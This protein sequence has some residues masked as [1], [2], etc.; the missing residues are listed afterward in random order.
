VPDSY[1]PARHI[2]RDLRF[3]MDRSEES[4]L[5][6]RM[7][8][9]P[10]LLDEH[11]VL[12]AGALGIATDVFGG[13]LSIEAALPDWAVT[14]E[15]Q[16]H[17]LGQVTKG[18]VEVRGDVLRSGRTSV[19]LEVEVLDGEE[20]SAAVGSM[21]F[22]KIKRRHDNPVLPVDRPASTTLALEDS[23]FRSP[24]LDAIGV[25]DAPD[26]PAAIE[27]DLAPYVLN[28][29]DALQGG[30]VTTLVEVVAARVASHALGKPVVTTDFS[31][32]FLSLGTAGPI[33]ASA[34]LLRAEGDHALLRVEL[35]DRGQENRLLSMAT[36]R[37]GVLGRPG[38]S[39]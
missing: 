28:S 3:D 17:V 6:V 18:P 19:V 9:V 37:A 39:R 30:L 4:G 14:S 26:D 38:N 24:L 13:N 8:L 22:T 20:R 35:R 29:V 27:L 5:V 31:V 21:S 25:R 12:R 33:R 32:H 34:R 15:L 2:L 1:P 23:Y 36:A 11:G 16:L 7:D 10:E